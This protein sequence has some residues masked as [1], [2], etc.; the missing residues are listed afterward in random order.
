MSGARQAQA[1]GAADP[2]SNTVVA[3]T[4]GG[5]FNSGAYTQ[6]RES[7]PPG[8]VRQGRNGVTVRAKLALVYGGLFVATGLVLTTVAY[9]FVQWRLNHPRAD[10]PA[11]CSLT[12]AERAAGQKLTALQTAECTRIVR[13]DTLHDILISFLIGLGITALLAFLV[14]FWVAGRV[15]RPLSRVTETAR[16]IA[17]RPDEA[18]STRIALSGPP[19]ELRELADTFDEMLDRLDTAFESQRRFTGN[20][21]HELRTPLAIKR[22]LLEVALADPDIH[23]QTEQLARAVLTANE[24]SE[25]MV[26]GLLALAKAQNALLEP[27]AVALAEVAAQALG[28]C[29]A[30]SVE[31]SV[32][33]RADLGRVQV[34]GDAGLLERV[35][36]NLV[37]NAM[38]Y[39]V[40][41]GWVDVV[42]H[43]QDSHGLL[44]VANSGPA[45]PEEA[46]AVM[47]EPFRRFQPGSG[48]ADPGDRGAGLG[49]SIVRA[50]VSAHRGRIAVQPRPDGGL[51][52]R[53]WIPAG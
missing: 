3:M 33:L 16:W 14:A 42:T 23:P 2:M 31:R 37:Q 10:L 26:E 24:R 32:R 46:V 19:D 1:D 29:Q 22:T 18:R 25:R 38:R 43:D 15:L 13:T 40:P 52:V 47:F 27:G 21:S 34:L 44:V 36:T 50:V 20:A 7:A 51:I 53:V 48:A 5:G 4:V 11:W 9:L 41:D 49:L 8:S 28:L 17:A 35:A 12:Q 30:E 39:N 6:A 45:V